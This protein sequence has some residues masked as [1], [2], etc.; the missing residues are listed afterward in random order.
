MGVWG[1]AVGLWWGLRGAGGVL[2]G[3]VRCCGCGGGVSVGLRGICVVLW[4]FWDT[5]RGSKGRPVGLCVVL[6]GRMWRRGGRG[7]SVGP[8]EAV[9][10]C[11]SGPSVGQGWGSGSGAECGERAPAFSGVRVWGVGGWVG[12]PVRGDI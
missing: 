9:W 2:S 8:G 6:W 11:G 5:L 12:V 10:G 1:I 4:V 7:V 3:S